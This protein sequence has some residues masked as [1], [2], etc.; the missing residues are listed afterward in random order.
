MNHLMN[1]NVAEGLFVEVEAVGHENRHI[2]LSDG[3]LL[4]SPS[5]LET[6]QVATGVYETK[7][8]G[9]QLVVEVL[10]VAIPKHVGHRVV[11]CYHLSSK[12]A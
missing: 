2:T 3:L 5:I 12:I 4:F 9:T 8:G 1:H 10:A 7:L 11:I 6:A